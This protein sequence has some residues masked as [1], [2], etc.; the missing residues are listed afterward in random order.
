MSNN[1]GVRTEFVTG[2]A[3]SGKSFMFKS[4]IA[5]DPGCAVLCAT[6]GV[7]AVNLDTVTINSVLSYF[8]TDSLID[9][10]VRG[11][12]HRKLRALAQ[13]D[14]VRDIVIDEVSML[15]AEQLDTIYKAI[16]EVNVGD[17][18]HEPLK[19][20][21]GLTLTGDA[22]QL[23]PVKGR[24]FFTADCWPEFASNT[25]R[26]TKIYRQTD[27]A[28]LAAINHARAG[29]G[30]PAAR[31][32]RQLGAQ[33]SLATDMNY[34][35][36][37]IVAKN[38]EA[39]R[40]NSQRLLKIPHPSFALEAVRWGQQ[41]PEWRNIPDRLILKPTCLVMLLA[42]KKDQV[43]GQFEYV[44][45][46]LAHVVR[47]EI[48]AHFYDW[49]GE[50]YTAPGVQVTSLR[51]NRTFW[52]ERIVREN[53]TKD[54]PDPGV[55]FH[56]DEENKRYVIGTVDWFPMRLGYCSTVH[57]SQ[58]L[59]L[60]RVQIDA[61]DGFFGAPSMA[62]VAL[63]RARTVEG[64]RIVGDPNLLARRIKLNPEVREWL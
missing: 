58:G 37:T 35:G 9:K 16:H 59:S 14:R 43:T 42:N 3:G 8:D 51:T 21:L 54:E 49:Q 23:P 4:R 55:P 45:G 48:D 39:D 18:A 56:F 15:H 46:D 5:D 61:R 41:S 20:P 24:W 64:M 53:T 25:T 13:P 38:A 62:Y 34:D 12:V 10:Y 22:C 17:D 6:T 27:P 7:A 33:F 28:F 50:E 29:E 57:K 2:P 31:G 36:T 11:H 19:Y 30:E 32:L 63:S 44:N 60:D 40:Y 47:Y 26:L 52:V 1:N